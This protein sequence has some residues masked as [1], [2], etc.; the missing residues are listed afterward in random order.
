MPVDLKLY[1]F[2][3]L[4]NDILLTT[5][6]IQ[7]R[8]IDNEWWV[9]EQT[10]VYYFKVLYQNLN[11]GTVKHHETLHLVIRERFDWVS[12]G[13]YKCANHHTAMFCEILLFFRKVTGE[14]Y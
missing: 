11:E 3:D 14:L 10:V 5:Y 7:R 12:F 13:I 2:L 4:F 1:D 6:I 9:V 8:M